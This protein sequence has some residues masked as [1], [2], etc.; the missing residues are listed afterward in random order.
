[1]SNFKLSDIKIGYADGEKEANNKNFDNLF[2]TGNKKYEQLTENHKFIISGRKGTGKTLL[3]KYFQKMNAKGK[4]IINYSKLKEISLHEYIDIESP[5]ISED[6]R[7]LFQ[8]FYIYKQLIITTLDNKLSFINFISS[9]ITWKEKLLSPYYFFQYILIY[10]KI[11]AL[12][13]D[14]YPD[15][16]YKEKEVKTI[17]TIV[18]A[19]SSTI[20]TNLNFELEV[21]GNESTELSREVILKRQNFAELTEKFRTLIFDIL[22]Y[23]NII[24]MIDDLDE[25][26]LNDSEHIIRFLINFV[27]KVS[28][29]N[30][31]LQKKSVNSKCILLLR[32]DII[33]SFNTRSSNIQKILSD[34]VVE[35]QWFKDKSGNEL[36][37]MIMYK[38]QKSSLDPS[39]ST[40]NLNQIRDK[41][42]CKSNHFDAFSYILNYTFGRPRDFITY[43]DNI[44]EQFPNES[45]FTIQMAK[46]VEATYSDKF[47]G[48]LKNEMSFTLPKET[49]DDIEK[50]LRT[51]GKRKFK[52]SNIVMHYNKN[53]D[54][55]SHINNIEET[56][57]LLYK[58]GVIGNY[59][60][61]D[62]KTL[63]SW[64]YRNGGEYLDKN[65]FIMIHFGLLKSLNI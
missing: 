24:L 49:I 14:L 19:S 4:T 42:F 40:L 8:E 59:T 21:G 37:D 43:I 13:K 2:Y 46:E 25:I 34:S 35:L 60:K 9:E 18:E 16:I 11:N 45:Q 57:Q 6:T 48:E 53:K 5:N 27:T 54:L 64:S 7:I 36:S 26:Q 30:M 51:F 20:K 61:K 10:N 32:S 29:I 65:K 22:K 38:I 28:T 33:S 1:M 52:Y 31:Q 63:Y 56:L 41:L 58:F 39:L 47:Y 55:Y 44:I 62:K 17:Q 3:T 23:I 15:G 50:L 12:Y